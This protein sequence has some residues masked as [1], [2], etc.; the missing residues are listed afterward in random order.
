MEYQKKVKLPCWIGLIIQRSHVR[1]D[2]L[3]LS[4]LDCN[5]IRIW[6]YENMEYLKKVKLCFPNESVDSVDPPCNSEIPSLNL[7]MRK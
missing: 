7:A 2:I 5:N 3:L 1:V 6:M 4:D